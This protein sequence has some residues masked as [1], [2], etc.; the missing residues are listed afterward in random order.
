MGGEAGNEART[1][2]GGEA[3]NEARTRVGERL[4]MRLERESGRG[5]YYVCPLPHS[6]VYNTSQST[7]ALGW[8]TNGQNGY[9]NRSQIMKCVK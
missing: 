9:L 6:Q 3:G 2:V 7:R 4:G 8:D 1:R 5:W